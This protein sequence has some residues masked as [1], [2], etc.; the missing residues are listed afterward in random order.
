MSLD[1]LL[2]GLVTGATYGLLGLGLTLVHRLS[3][4]LNLAHGELG[5]FGAATC[6][7]LAVRFGWPLPLALAA[8]VAGA[9]LLAGAA[10]LIVVKRLGDRPQVVAMVA[11]IGVGQL[12]ALL[13]VSLPDIALFEP[14]PTLGTQPVAIGPFDLSP[15]ELGALVL[16]PT[17]GIGVWWVLARTTA[18]AVVRATAANPEAARLSGIDA[19]LVSSLV[20]ISAGSLAAVATI[21]AVPLRGGTAA[22]V[23]T[24]GPGLLLRGFAA[25]AV[26]RLRSVPLVLAGGLAIGVAEALV[27]R[28][29]SDPG[30]ANLVVFAVVMIGLA[31]LPRSPAAVPAAVPTER[32]WSDWPDSLRVRVARHAPAVVMVAAIVALPFL[33][34]G[35]GATFQLG[36][37]AIVAMVV[38]SATALGGWSG[39]V[40]L[41]QFTLAGLGAIVSARVIAAGAPWELALVAGAA[42]AAL[43]AAVLAIPAARLRGAPLAMATLG[44]AVMAP[45]WLFRQAWTGDAQVFEVPRVAF[46]GGA[47]DLTSQRTYYLFVL[48]V[49]GAAVG[50]L[51]WLSVRRPGRAW[52]AVMDNEAAAAAMGV[53]PW[54]T[55]V[56]S[57]VAAGA[58]AGLAGGL[59]AGLFVTFRRGAFAP[60]ESIEVVVMAVIG[61]LGSIAG[62]VAGVAYVGALPAFFSDLESLQ[63]L[64]S[65][66]GLLALLVY[67]PDGIAG[68]VGRLQRL[69]AGPPAR[70][71]T[72]VPTQTAPTAPTGP[73]DATVTPITSSAR[74]LEVDDIVVSF[75][76]VRA[77]DGV[78]LRIEPGTIVGLIGPNGAGKSTLLGAISGHVPSRGRVTIGDLAV[79]GWSPDRR[80]RAGLG[81]TFQDARL[82]PSLT[83]RDVALVAAARAA[84]PSA[85]A[86]AAL[87]ATGLA[88]FADER[89]GVLS[90]GTRRILELACLEAGE[91]D[92]LLLDEPTAG[93]AQREV[94]AF[95][96]VLRA[97]RD[98]LDAT[99]VIVE[100]DVAML[101]RVCDRLVCLESGRLLADGT[102]DE[103]RNDP[104]VIESYLGTEAAAV[105]RS[106]T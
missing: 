60:D 9:A 4:T 103:V 95:P 97:L 8:G 68:V 67:F 106:M 52:R 64:V 31:T 76:G 24:L 69:A 94:E 25:A 19:G 3:G 53:S 84:D 7:V 46:A 82:Y 17:I 28:W 83:V 86:A 89:C 45:A 15:A 85:T 88:D 81:R 51:G 44:L 26:G 37:L 40:S 57:F 78:G 11:T 5:A 101:G 90:T 14:F 50:V 2:V 79:G 80:A 16:V 73:A 29:S 58:L 62:A 54:R 10:E 96:G 47:L 49:G 1:L 6:A 38:V 98:R 99:I 32:P 87:A 41:A 100:H 66:V 34:T 56:A 91:G 65:G 93:L 104:A 71:G 63:L 59:W 61:G 33:V 21:A 74:A 55:R 77:V 39:Q 72:A 27:L 70:S 75:G 18:G 13:R 23:A 43:A 36:R 22:A 102:P 30:A 12:C 35:A 105:D 42:A 20:W 48:A 92:V